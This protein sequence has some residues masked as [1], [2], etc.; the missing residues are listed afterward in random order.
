MARTTAAGAAD[1]VRAARMARLGPAAG[2]VNGAR[3]AETVEA[4]VSSLNLPVTGMSCAACAVRVQKALERT[5]GVQ[6]AAVNFGSE[7]AR[8][9]FNPRLVQPGG[10]VDAVS[11]IGYGV[12]L[13]R[14]VLQLDGLD[15]AA[16][17]APVER[18]LLRV[19]GVV[20]AEA[21][22]A[23]Q[24]ARVEYIAGATSAEEL[25]GAVERAGYHLAEPVEAE[26]AAERERLV[27][28][29]ELGRMTRK[30]WVSLA[31][32]LVAMLVA[33]PL[34]AAVSGPADLFDRLMMPLARAARVVVPWL[35][36]V[37]PSILRWALL[38][39]T[40]PVVVWAGR[41]FYRGAWSGLLH[42]SADMNTLVA[43]GTGSAYSY[44]LLVT[45]APGLFQ[46]AGIGADVYYEAVSAII[47]LVLLGKILEA[48]AKGRTSEAIRKLVALAPPMARVVRD[49]QEQ[50][51]KAAEV[52][53]GDVVAVRPGERL[54]VDGIVVDGHSAIDQSLVTGESLPVE[55][56]AGDEVIGGTINA[57]GAF[58]FRA[59]RVGRDTALAQVVRLV[60]EA[61]ASRAP[62]QRLADRIAGIFVPVVVGVGVVAFAAWLILGPQPSFLFGLV[63]FV[64][65][66]I[67]ACPCAMGLATPTAIMVGTGAGAE[68]GVLIKDASTLERAQRLEAIVLDKTGTVT[69]GQPRVVEVMMAAGSIDAP[70]RGPKAAR[71]RILR[72]AASLEQAS[73]HPLGS[74]IVDAARSRGI[75]LSPARA[76][77]AVPGRGA[78]ADIDGTEVLV[79]NAAFLA[80]RGVD[81]ASLRS[82]A[83]RCAADASTPVFVAAD[84][85]ALGVL[86]IADP[87]KPTSAA[88]IAELRSLGLQVVML[89]G[90][91]R[92]TAEA[93]ARRVGVDRVVAE[94]L[95]ADKAL[96]VQRL[97][98]SGRTVAMVG[99]GIND[100]PALAQADVGIAIGTGT[101]VAVEASDITLISGDLKGVVTAI[102]LSRR[103]VGVIR[104]NLFWALIY[105]VL[106]IPIAAG[107]LY[108][109]FGVLLSPVIA[110]A[111][112]AFS[113]V[114]VVG[115]SLRLRRAALS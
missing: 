70:E 91:H 99:D 102:R 59:T 83:E 43:I 53:V 111:A 19:P 96:E 82:D 113:S 54:P 18:E 28:Q 98:A 12:A 40:T 35:F 23:T 69:E 114:S 13:S 93:V 30:F 64:T 42:G 38:L 60:E 73:E 108:P 33:L 77:R 97:Q 48:R 112:M 10:L 4:G 44:S 52:E 68:R 88:A 2:A 80:D 65:V 81:I 74:A 14:S 5:R 22:L 109:F 78:Q 25:E 58:R 62:I 1:A 56:G 75:S 37:D 17:A 85:Q 51:V 15:S 67:I 94:V 57:S 49:G 3:T 50:D 101:D 6:Q 26:D 66:L 24:Q 21:N 20:R 27:R 34:M 16:S 61:Q 11:R 106:G 115:N 7:R 45:V 36:G 55:I 110:S 39:L 89:T 29:R 107:V 104:E 76:F 32:T 103:T 86:A 100:A 63:S 84:G 71:L 105:N 8:V 46:R 95:P 90:D 92:R 79:G 47:A 72:L 31:V 87:V 41:Q 9:E